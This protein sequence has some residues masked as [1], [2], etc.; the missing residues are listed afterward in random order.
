M[1]PRQ[2]TQRV[3]FDDAESPPL[4]RL[5]NE[6]QAELLQSGTRVPFGKVAYDMGF[7]NRSQLDSALADQRGDFND[8]FLD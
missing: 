8:R 6:R 7:I 3:L 2:I 5:Q 1:P 4:P